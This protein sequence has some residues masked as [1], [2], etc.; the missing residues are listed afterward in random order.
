[1]NSCI[2]GYILFQP[3]LPIIIKVDMQLL[4]AIKGI[5]VGLILLWVCMTCVF[6]IGQ[7]HLLSTLLQKQKFLFGCH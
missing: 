2:D 1:M 3:C 7:T 5:R 6:I 4:D